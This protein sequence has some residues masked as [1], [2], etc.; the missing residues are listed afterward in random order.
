[1]VQPMQPFD[2]TQH[3]QDIPAQDIL[4]LVDEH[5]PH[6]SSVART[7][8]AA[9]QNDITRATSAITVRS[10]SSSKLHDINED[11]KTRITLGC[12]AGAF[13]KLNLMH[14][15]GFAQPMSNLV[16]RDFYHC[17]I[18]TFTEYQPTLAA[19][20]AMGSLSTKDYAEIAFEMR[21]TARLEAR[22]QMADQAAVGAL[23][24]RDLAKY[25]HR[26]GPTFESLY[27][28]GIDRGLSEE[29]ASRRIIDSSTRTN[30]VADTFIGIVRMFPMLDSLI[31]FE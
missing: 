30:T 18:Q 26:D 19:L 5:T 22:A 25:G 27:Q 16:T 2:Q 1:M 6:M 13:E 7:T 23:E 29:A 9:Y 31:S 20:N 14:P 12:M 28:S 24:R 3:T 11:L 10:I 21:H 17:W 15:E 4:H 8:F